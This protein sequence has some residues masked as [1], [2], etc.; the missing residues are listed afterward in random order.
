MLKSDFEM[1]TLKNED[2]LIKLAEM[3][4]RYQEVCDRTLL[5]EKISKQKRDYED[6]FNSQKSQKYY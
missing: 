4:S 3:M 1:I 2:Y 5:L 6:E